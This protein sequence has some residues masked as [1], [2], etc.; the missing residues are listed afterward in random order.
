MGERGALG[1]PGMRWR[2][3]APAAQDS[4]IVPMLMYF[5]AVCFVQYTLPCMGVRTARTGVLPTEAG[6]EPAE[7]HGAV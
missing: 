1:L 4:E 3:P 7:G 6:L 2:G 5:S